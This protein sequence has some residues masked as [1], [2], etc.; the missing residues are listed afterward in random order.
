[1]NFDDDFVKSYE[2]SVIRI[3]YRIDLDSLLKFLG[4]E[5]P[6]F[7]LSSLF[8]TL[9][10]LVYGRESFVTKDYKYEAPPGRERSFDIGWRFNKTWDLFLFSGVSTV[11]P[12]LVP[13]SYGVEKKFLTVNES[14]LGL[15]YAFP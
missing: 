5:E 10:P 4:K 12:F 14:Y 7:I 2:R 8:L 1:M 15:H 9:Y 11:G 3:G 13:T 6:V